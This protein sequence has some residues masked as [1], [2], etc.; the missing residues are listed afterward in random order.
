VQGVVEV[1]TA[2]RSV[3]CP[4]VLA[5]LILTSKGAGV[6]SLRQLAVAPM[7]NEMLFGMDALEGGVLVVDSVAGVWEW[8]LKRV[9]GG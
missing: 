5:G 2:N 1:A 9:A 3:A 7:T 4:V 6:H 8:D